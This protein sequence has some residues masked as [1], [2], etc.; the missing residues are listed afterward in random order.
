[1]SYIPHDWW[2]ICNR[3]GIKFRRSEMVQEFSGKAPE[4]LWV[5]KTSLDPV[6]PQEYVTSIDD[7]P[8]VYPAYPDVA[9][10]VGETAMAMDAAAGDST[11]YLEPRAGSVVNDPIGITANDGTTFWTFIESITNSEGI[12]RDVNGEILYD[13]N[14]EILY[15][16]EGT[17]SKVVINAHIH[18]DSDTGN[19]V[20]LP[21][22]NNEEW[23]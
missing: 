8:S 19:T 15:G 7:D 10:A 21:S 16:F 11:L 2:V 13:S 5:H 14:G 3:T 4:G 23:Q 17:S 20:Y 12:L 1:M 18:S 6:H 22:L 9:Q